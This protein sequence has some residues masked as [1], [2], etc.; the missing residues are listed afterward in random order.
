MSPG[1]GVQDL[2]DGVAGAMA[3]PSATPPINAAMVG[4][5]AHRPAT[6]GE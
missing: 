3:P 1:G 4:V 6:V 2:D 5:P